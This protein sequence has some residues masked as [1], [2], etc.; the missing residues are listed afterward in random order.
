MLQPSPGMEPTRGQSQET[1]ERPQWHEWTGTI[2]RSQD[3]DF[4]ASVG[5][6]LVRQSESRGVKQSEGAPKEC[7][8]LLHAP[9]ECQ[10]FL[11][12]FGCLQVRHLQTDHDGR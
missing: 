11:L 1:Q 2:D 10:D 12:E 7:R 9:S 8:E 5:Q 4:S 3:S 6:T